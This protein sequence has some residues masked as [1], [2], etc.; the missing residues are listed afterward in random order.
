[1]TAEVIPFPYARR[2]DGLYYR[3]AR[4]A[5][6]LRPRKAAEHVDRQLRIQAE[7]MRRRGIVEA[8]IDAELQV[9]RVRVEL[10]SAALGR[11]GRTG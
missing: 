10:A 9:L 2:E 11:D 5:A 7:A 1:M 6:E 8:R 3:I 4:R